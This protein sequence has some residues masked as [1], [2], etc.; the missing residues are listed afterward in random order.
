M[1]S[2][3]GDRKSK[4]K[5][6]WLSG[7]LVVSLL[8]SGGALSLRGLTD[9]RLN[10]LLAKDK[11][12]KGNVNAAL[13][14]SLDLYQKLRPFRMGAFLDQPFLAKTEDSVVAALQ[15]SINGEFQDVRSLVDITSK[16][17]S[18]TSVV[19]SPDGQTI[20]SGSGDKTIKLWNA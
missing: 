12:A 1:A 5:L 11:Y 10:G 9:L 13:V 7:L 17:S 8:S 3:S 19:F 18:V 14:E 4:T 15:T 2:N 20:A 16:D 6:K